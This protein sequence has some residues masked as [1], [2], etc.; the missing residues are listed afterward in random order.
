MYLTKLTNEMARI[1]DDKIERADKVKISN[2]RKTLM[3]FIKDFMP[4]GLMIDK[5]TGSLHHN[6]YSKDLTE[7]IIETL[8]GIEDIGAEKLMATMLLYE[9]AEREK[10]LE[11]IESEER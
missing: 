7:E 6:T 8:G 1:Y 3:I 11:D 9:Y 10:I 5:D 4:V 2:G